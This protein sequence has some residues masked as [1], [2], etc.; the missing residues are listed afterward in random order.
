MAIFSD[1]LSME[2]TRPHDAG[3]PSSRLATDQDAGAAALSRASERQKNFGN[4]VRETTR[5]AL[6]A[7]RGAPIGLGDS[8]DTTAVRNVPAIGA[9]M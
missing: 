4:F 9:R 2:A 8:R 1:L 5:R 6:I 7:R 3:R